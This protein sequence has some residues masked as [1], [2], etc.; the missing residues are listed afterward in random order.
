MKFKKAVKKYFLNSLGIA[1]II[2]LAILLIASYSF[3]QDEHVSP[4]AKLAVDLQNRADMVDFAQGYFMKE[5]FFN[6][7]KRVINAIG[8]EQLKHL[9]QQPALLVQMFWAASN[10]GQVREDIKYLRGVAKP[11]SYIMTSFG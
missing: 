10:K 11:D 1:S 9:L 8:D 6:S 4:L 2:T 5:S 3:S 7:D